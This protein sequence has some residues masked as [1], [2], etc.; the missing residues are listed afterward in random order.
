MLFHKR[1]YVY[2]CNTWGMSLC[3]SVTLRSLMKQIKIKRTDKII[4]FIL[5]AGIALA[6]VLSAS[7]AQESTA[8]TAA[9]GR[10]PSRWD[11]LS[12][13]PFSILSSRRPQ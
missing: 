9:S 7:C 1:N 13:R 12:G 4:I 5:I 2:N 11:L 8:S 10:R 3:Y 6:A